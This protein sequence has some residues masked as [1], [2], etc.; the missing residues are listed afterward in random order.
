MSPGTKQ[1][2]MVLLARNGM[3][4]EVAGMSIETATNSDNPTHWLIKTVLKYLSILNISPQGLYCLNVSLAGFFLLIV[5]H[6][7]SLMSQVL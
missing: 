1:G 5:P 4:W 6:I 7:P 3:R 2:N